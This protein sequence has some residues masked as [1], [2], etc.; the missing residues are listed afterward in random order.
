MSTD[1]FSEIELAGEEW[2]DVPGFDGYQV[3][4]LGRMRGKFRLIK[5]TV[6]I[7][8][9][10]QFWLTKES[11]VIPCY[12]HRLVLGSFVG[13]ALD[14]TQG[15]HF[16]GDRTNNRLSNLRW[17]TVAKNHADKKRHGT[18]NEGEKHA[19]TKLNDS[20]VVEMRALYLSGKFSS[21]ALARKYGIAKVVA[22]NAIAGRT[23]KHIAGEIGI[24]DGYKNRRFSTKSE[25]NANAKLTMALASEIRDAYKKGAKS[26][27][28]ATIYGVGKSTINRVLR[29]DTFAE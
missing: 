18:S 11:K 19:L 20:N 4:S 5:G 12:G 9:Y 2:R 10:R 23:F 17:D 25:D 14:G 26:V 29:M 8:G 1:Q 16:D 21:A 27:D 7:H 28:L 3:S 6:N 22:C 13:A 15:C 24:K